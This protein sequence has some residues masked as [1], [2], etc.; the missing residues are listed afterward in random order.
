MFQLDI[1]LSDFRKVNYVT[2]LDSYPLP[3]VEDCV[4]QV[5]AAKYVSKFDLLKG[6]LQ[7]PLTPQAQE[8]SAFVTPSGLF[9]YTVMGFR[10]RNA[11]ATFQRL[12]NQV[13]NG[14][15]G[16]ALYLDDVIVHSDTWEEHMARIRAL[17]DRLA[18]GN[19]MVNLAKSEFAKVTVTYL[20]KVVGQGHVRPVDAKVSAIVAFPTLTT[21]RVGAVPR[22]SWVS[23]LFPPQLFIFGCSPD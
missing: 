2:K 9:S 3:Q 8:I 15:A 20:G 6:Y 17:F 4:D 18:D 5:G 7:V 19:L 16:Y 10:L 21:K 1:S 14:L 11:P 12:M 23:P 22:F 13:V